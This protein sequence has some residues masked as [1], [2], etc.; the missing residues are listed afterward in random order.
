MTVDPEEEDDDEQ[1]WGPKWKKPQESAK[2]SSSAVYPKI[3]AKR[4]PKELRAQ[5]MKKQ[6]DEQIQRVSQENTA[7]PYVTNPFDGSAPKER[8]RKSRS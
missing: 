6:Q 2:P 7:N 4:A 8:Q 3:Q 1:D 5:W